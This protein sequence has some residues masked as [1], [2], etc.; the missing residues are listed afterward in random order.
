MTTFHVELLLVISLFLF[1]IFLHLRK[2]YE[3]FFIVI[4]QPPK[5]KKKGE[6]RRFSKEVRLDF[7][8]QKG[9]KFKFTGKNFTTEQITLTVSNIHWNATEKYIW[10][11]F[12]DLEEFSDEREENVLRY[13]GFR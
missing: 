13:N 5:G 2:K 4:I 1:M 9:Q 10:A 6:R 3:I 12:E 8:P 7:I 11:Q